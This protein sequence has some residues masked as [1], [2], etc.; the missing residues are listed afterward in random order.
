M[1]AMSSSAAF[2]S[3]L[4]ELNITPVVISYEYEPCDFL[5]TRELYIS[6]RKPYI[7]DDGEDMLSIL[8]GIKQGK[9]HIHLAVCET[10]SEEELR[11]CDWFA[12]NEKFKCLVN[13]IDNKIYRNY[14]LWKTN[15]IAFDMLHQ[16]KNYISYYSEEERETFQAYMIKGL[17]EI[18]GDIEELKTIFLQIYATPVDNCHLLQSL[19]RLTD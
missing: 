10:V 17:K 6:K 18:E 5:K 8:K 13:I 15:Y 2:V 12:H 16:S 1:F 11:E 9:G 3:N 7:K 4:M 14:R 19:S